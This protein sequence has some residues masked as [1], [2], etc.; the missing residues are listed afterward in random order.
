MNKLKLVGLALGLAVASS[1]NAGTIVVDALGGPVIMNSRNLGGL[2]TPG[3]TIFSTPSLAE[4]HGSVN[5]DGI[6][7]D[8]RVTFLLADTA[9]GL[10]FFTLIDTVGDFQPPAGGADDSILGFSS[11][12]PITANRYIN[13]NPGDNIQWFNLLNGTQLATGPFSWNSASD[14][15][16]FAWGNLLLGDAVSFHFVNQGAA[17]L[18][19]P[20]TFQFLS[21]NGQGWHVVANGN[22]TSNNQFV[23]SFTTVPA[24][25]AFAL[26]GIGALVGF[27]RRRRAA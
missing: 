12:A 17:G 8:G 14:G 2:L 23:F 5:G 22:F 11:T 27:S 26:L 15:D 19:S 25:G 4:L 9:D 20:N 21:F 13:D 7:T 24:P 16:G 10:S 3:S 1:A 18:L 6:S